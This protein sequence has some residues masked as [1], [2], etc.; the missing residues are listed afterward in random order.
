M[1]GGD[2]RSFAQPAFPQPASAGTDDVILDEAKS[3][4]KALYNH[5]YIYIY[6]YTY[7]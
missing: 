1:R 2:T 7:T 5:V 3:L 6:I 4:T